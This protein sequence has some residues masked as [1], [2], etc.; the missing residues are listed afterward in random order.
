MLCYV[1]L[2]ERKSINPCASLLLVSPDENDEWMSQ[3]DSNFNSVALD[4]ESGQESTRNRQSC[5][6]VNVDCHKNYRLK[7]E[8]RTQEFEF[9]FKKFADS[10]ETYYSGSI[11]IRADSYTL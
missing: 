2:K 10:L 4:S 3:I 9:E 11:K 5:L 1:M 8:E 7:V 6:P